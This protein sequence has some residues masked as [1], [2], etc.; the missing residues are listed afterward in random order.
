VATREK[1]IM[2]VWEPEG[3]RVPPLILRAMTS[4]RMARSTALLSAGTSGRRTQVK[5][6]NVSQRRLQLGRQVCHLLP[7]LCLFLPQV[8]VPRHHRRILL[9]RHRAPSVV[10]GS[11]LNSYTDTDERGSAT[12]CPAPGQVVRTRPKTRGARPPHRSP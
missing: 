2:R 4:G 8:G 7:E 9:V 5:R 10:H 6:G 1:R 3:E 12:A 11:T